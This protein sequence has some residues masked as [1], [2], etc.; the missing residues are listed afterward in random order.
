MPDDDYEETVACGCASC[1]K[2]NEKMEKSKQIERL[3][4]VIDNQGGNANVTW[5]TLHAI[6]KI[7]KIMN[8]VE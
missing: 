2:I 3:F 1:A 6:I 7:L 4:D 5:N 8:D